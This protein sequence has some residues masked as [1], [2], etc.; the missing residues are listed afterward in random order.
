MVTAVS[1]SSS[2]VGEEVE[3]EYESIPTL[4]PLGRLFMNRLKNLLLALVVPLAAVLLLLGMVV[5]VRSF[6]VV[7]VVFVGVGSD[8]DGGRRCLVSMLVFLPV[9]SVFVWNLKLQSCLF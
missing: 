5:V 6:G 8:G 2:V 9:L 1:V 7:M 4:R 3:G